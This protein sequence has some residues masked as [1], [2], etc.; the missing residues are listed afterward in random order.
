M[1]GSSQWTVTTPGE[2]KYF[3]DAKQYAADIN[4]KFGHAPDYHD[5]EASAAC[6]ALVLAIEKAGS[7]DAGAVRDALAGLDTDSFFGHIKFNDKGQ[8]VYKPMSVI[9]IQDGKAVTVWPTDNAEAELVW[10]GTK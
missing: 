8:N 5:A 6:L 2:D 7:T 1:L 3:G 4:D 10:P 9:Q